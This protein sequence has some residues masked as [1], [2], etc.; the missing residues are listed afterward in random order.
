MPDKKYTDAWAERVNFSTLRDC[1]FI[2]VPKAAGSSVA[3][4][5]ELPASSHLTFAELEKTKFYR[6]HPGLMVFA[7]VRNPLMRFISLYHYARMPVSS[8]HNNIDPGKG[9]Y[10]AHLD[11]QTLSGVGLDEAVDLLVAGELVHDSR[12]NQWMP[13]VGWTRSSSM[14][15]D[16]RIHVIRLESL[17]LGLEQLFGV[18]GMD[19]PRL[20]P[21]TTSGKTEMLSSP[22]MAKLIDYY[23]DDYVS[24]GYG[25][26][27]L[28]NG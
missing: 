14:L 6:R 10:G 1:V 11:Y 19:L 5:L 25:T 28:V 3:Q 18:Q 24:F 7:V 27:A 17:Q 8:Y 20:N 9:L 26:D 23:Y 22:Q 13:Q 15:V 2:H 16:S 4:L 12:W 21:S